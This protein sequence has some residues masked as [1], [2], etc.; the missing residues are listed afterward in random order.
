M[1]HL[2]SRHKPRPAAAPPGTAAATNPHRSLTLP[3]DWDLYT[4]FQHVQAKGYKMWPPSYEDW[5]EAD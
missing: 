5:P 1:R 2:A 4:V 3:N